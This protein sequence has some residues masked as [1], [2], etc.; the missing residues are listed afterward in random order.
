M[1]KI[2]CFTFAVLFLSC[3][4]AWGAEED[5]STPTPTKTPYPIYTPDPVEM[6]NTIGDADEMFEKIARVRGLVIRRKPVVQFKGRDFFKEYFEARLHEDMSPAEWDGLS[7]AEVALG[8]SNKPRDLFR[9]E[10]DDLLEGVQ[11]L[12]DPRV[13]VLYLADWLD[14]KKWE[15]VLAHELVHCLQDQYMDLGAYLDAMKG[16]TGDERTARACIIEGEATALAYDYRIKKDDPRKSFLDLADITQTNRTEILIAAG[17]AWVRGD[18]GRL[19]GDFLGFAYA[20]GATFL[21]KYVKAK[22][23]GAVDGLYSHPPLS[24]EQVMDPQQ[25]MK[26]RVKPIRI[27]ISGLEKG[28]LEGYRKIWEDAQGTR[29]L[30]G[31]LNSYLWKTRVRGTVKGWKGDLLQ[32]YEGPKANRFVTL[33]YV[34]FDG[35][36]NADS[37]FDDCRRAC[38]A[39]YDDSGTFSP[40]MGHFEMKTKTGKQALV[41]KRGKRVV[42]LD[43]VTPAQGTALVREILKK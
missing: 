3:V 7:K 33:V 12:Y 27:K 5:L 20:Y 32:V 31:L 11:G 22:G 39:R 40:E 15:E 37:F 10:V 8:L 30:N 25:F 36:E 41:E 16:L 24:T 28:P 9:E 35:E 13:K 1:K 26:K 43:G 14:T 34:L 4:F 21:Q 2:H 42:L 19:R 29:S 18:K 38:E 6:Q 17:R 23:W